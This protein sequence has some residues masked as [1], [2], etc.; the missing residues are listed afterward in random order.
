[1]AACASQIHAAKHID[2]AFPAAFPPNVPLK[3]TRLDT[4]WNLRGG[5]FEDF[6]VF[7][8]IPLLERAEDFV[9]KNPSSKLPKNGQ[10]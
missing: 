4:F 6:S 8:I 3:V 5:N 7:E 10:K 1:M 2:S 9:I